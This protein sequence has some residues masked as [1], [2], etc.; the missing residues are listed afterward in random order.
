[1]SYPRLALTLCFGSILFSGCIA[2]PDEADLDPVEDDVATA[3]QS[4]SDGM[5]RLKN[6]ATGTCLAVKADRT[7]LS[8]TCG[9]FDRQ[10]MTFQTYQ[11]SHGFIVQ[12]ILPKT[13]PGNVLRADPN[14]GPTLGIAPIDPW[15]LE[16]EWL[17]DA[18]SSSI[19]IR[20]L[21]GY[22]LRINTSNVPVFKPCDG[23]TRERWNAL[24]P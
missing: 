20:S 6:V 4:L 12:R 2:A 8:D 10:R 7:I 24:A 14:L 19:R 17:T 18:G 22:C 9:A 3:A 11:D 16:Q 13:V 23:N 21:V 5:V 1:M 15:A